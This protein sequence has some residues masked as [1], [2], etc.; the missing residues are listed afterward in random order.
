MGEILKIPVAYCIVGIILALVF[1]DVRANWVGLWGLGALIV[2]YA[3]LAKGERD[4]GRHE[5]GDN[6]YF[7]GFVYTLSIITFSLVFDVPSLVGGENSSGDFSPLLKTIG[8]ALGTSVVGMVCRFFLKQGVEVSEDAFDRA[9]SRAANSAAQLEGVVQNVEKLALGVER[10]IERTAEAMLM[11]SSMVEEETK[12]AGLSVGQTASAMLEEFGK[13]LDTT[14]R[15]VSE[16]TRTY[17]NQIEETANKIG[18]SLNHYAGE[19]FAELRQTL[20]DERLGDGVEMIRQSVETAAESI[21]SYAARV[22]SEAEMIGKSLNQAVSNTIAD[23]GDRVTDALQ[24]NQ[25]EE[26][27]QALHA[28]AGAH[29]EAV[30]DVKRTLA[31]SLGRLDDAVKISITNMEEVRTVLTSLEIAV[32][33]GPVSEMNRSLQR[34]ATEVGSLNDGLREL[35][36][37]QAATTTEATQD[38]ARLAEIRGAFDVL[39]HDMQSD[40]AAVSELR[41]SYRREFDN[42]AREALSETHGLYSRLISGA[43]V[44]LG[45]LDELGDV[46]NNLRTIANRIK[47]ESDDGL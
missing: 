32:D 20:A 15:R 25:I 43:E 2:L 13:H 45:G 17:S 10:S 27:N 35:A 5:V 12:K 8:I 30:A 34:F 29:E 42:A 33:E 6:C 46:A 9:V 41:E 28:A 36:N 11:Y 40:I 22:E 16:S 24:S 44:A 3:F 47:R 23:L 21:N 18:A 7:I 1:Q 39:M 31:E 37:T 19:L 38:V 4:S 14:L 26:A